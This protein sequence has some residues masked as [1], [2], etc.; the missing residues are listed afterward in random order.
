MSQFTPVEHQNAFPELNR[1]I[2]EEENDLLLHY[3]RTRKI[4]SGYWQDPSSSTEEM[5]PAFDGTGLA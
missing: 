5:I 4:T 1:R 3:L 2:S